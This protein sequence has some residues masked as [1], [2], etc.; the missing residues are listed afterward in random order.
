MINIIIII[1]VIEN[2]FSD[3]D[4]LTH[5]YRSKF[6]YTICAHDEQFSIISVAIILVSILRILAM[7]I[8]IIQYTTY[9]FCRTPSDI[10]IH[11]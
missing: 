3:C 8:C 6:S 2:I 1:V 7:Y 10:H 11:L 4:Q 9:L 5:Q